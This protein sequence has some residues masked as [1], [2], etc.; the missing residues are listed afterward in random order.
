MLMLK[1]DVCSRG[2]EGNGMVGW[3]WHLMPHLGGRF[4]CI[5]II[6]LRLRQVFSILLE[7]LVTFDIVAGDG[8]NF[9]GFLDDLHDDIRVRLEP[10]ADQDVCSG[11]SQTREETGAICVDCVTCGIMCD[12]GE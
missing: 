9:A 5:N 4:V 3:L 2:R 1:V 7:V 12:Q 6:E 10:K 8:G 11:C